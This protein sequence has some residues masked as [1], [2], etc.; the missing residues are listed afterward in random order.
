MAPSGARGGAGCDCV[1]GVKRLVVG[2][3]DG[4]DDSCVQE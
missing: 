1:G 3:D 2:N 4:D